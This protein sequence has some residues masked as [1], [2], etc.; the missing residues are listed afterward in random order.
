M[1]WCAHAFPDPF[2]NCVVCAEG[3]AG[4][5]VILS[6]TS[7][8]AAAQCRAAAT[9][10]SIAPGTTRSCVWAQGPGTSW[11]A[12]VA[13]GEGPPPGEGL[14]GKTG[15]AC[16][17]LGASSRLRLWGQPGRPAVGQER[18]AQ[19]EGHTAFQTV[20]QGASVWTCDAMNQPCVLLNVT[21][22]V[23]EC[24]V[25]SRLLALQL[26]LSGASVSLRV[27]VHACPLSVLLA[28][29]GPLR[30]FIPRLL[31]VCCSGGSGVCTLAGG[32]RA[33][34]DG[35]RGSPW[36]G[37]VQQLPTVA[38]QLLLRGSAWRSGAAGCLRCFPV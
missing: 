35:R 5:L 28:G 36:P 33:H 9:P 14:A 11:G 4:H 3:L 21:E 8:G 31:W 25:L 6:V 22:G 13:V 2:L 32:H 17:C 1:L 24:G 34:S 29:G 27:C 37:A 23:L 20:P 18:A 30:G 10:F 26:L 7:G 19:P 15:H 38:W 16:A 12:A